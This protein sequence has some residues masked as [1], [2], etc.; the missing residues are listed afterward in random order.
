MAELPVEP[1]EKTSGLRVGRKQKAFLDGHL[2]SH[3]P[4]K[5]RSG[6]KLVGEGADVILPQPN[7]DEIIGQ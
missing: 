5:G 2:G 7:K 3:V 4:D 1:L 6:P